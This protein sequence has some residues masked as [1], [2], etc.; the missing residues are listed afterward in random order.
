MKEHM[1]NNSSNK[2]KEHLGKDKNLTYFIRK[3]IPIV[4]TTLKL[5]NLKQMMV[6]LFIWNHS[7]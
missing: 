3:N 1:R 6:I 5:I 7:Y 2:F 4:S